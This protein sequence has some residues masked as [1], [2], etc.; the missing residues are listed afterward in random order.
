MKTALE[1]N[2]RKQ[3]RHPY[4]G[5]FSGCGNRDI[6]ELLMGL[7]T[8]FPNTAAWTAAYSTWDGCFLASVL[9]GWNR[10]RIRSAFMSLL[11]GT[12][13]PNGLVLYQFGEHALGRT[14]RSEVMLRSVRVLVGGHNALSGRAAYDLMA[15]LLDYPGVA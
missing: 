4:R 3:R 10:R 1:H 15:S 5:Y 14:G 7:K 11:K 9:H 13:H 6:I 2:K 12:N 8:G